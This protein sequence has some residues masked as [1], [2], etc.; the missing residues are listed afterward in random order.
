MRVTWVYAPPYFS[1]KDAFWESWSH[2]SWNDGTP[3]LVI[4]DFNE[5]LWSFEKEGGA[6]WNPRRCRYL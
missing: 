5:L 4:G 3:W 6:P 1:N 2:Q